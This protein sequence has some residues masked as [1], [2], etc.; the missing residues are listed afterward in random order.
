MIG[1]ALCVVASTGGDDTDGTFAS[2]KLQQFVP[3]SAFLE[4]PSH[5]QVIEFAVDVAAAETAE[6]H[7]IGAG[8]VINRIADACTGGAD[9]FQGDCGSGHGEIGA[10]GGGG[11]KFAS[12]RKV[13]RLPSASS[14]Q[15]AAMR[16]GVPRQNR[17]DWSTIIVPSEGCTLIN[18][19]PITKAR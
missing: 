5:L 2:G 9:D 6:A 14:G 12:R 8:T 10:G 19:T 1:Q 11:C 18:R 3:R 13:L 15:A 4:A 7:G 16:H 17:P